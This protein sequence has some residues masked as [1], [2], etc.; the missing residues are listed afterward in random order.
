MNTKRLLIFII[1]T[2]LIALIVMVSILN[3]FFKKDLLLSKPFASNISF[4]QPVDD[5]TLY[6]FSGSSFVSYDLETRKSSALTPQYEL[7]NIVK[8]IKW[9]K[10]GA[11]LHAVGYSPNDMLYTVLVQKQLSPNSDY[12]WLFDFTS[13]TFSLV[14]D[15]ATQAQVR[16]A[17]WQTD[18][19]F[20]YTEK[21]AADNLSVIKNEAGNA[22]KIAELSSTDTLE[23]AT[24]NTLLY[25][26]SNNEDLNRMD[27]QSKQVTPISGKVQTVLAVG[28]DTS[29][30][31]L[32]Q[33]A[34]TTNSDLPRGAL[35]L[36]TA[37]ANKVET[38]KPDFSGSAVWRLDQDLWL[39]V[40]YTSNN[41]VQVIANPK[42]QV[43]SFNLQDQ[44]EEASRYYLRAAGITKNN[45]VLVDATN[46]LLYASDTA[47]NDILAPANTEQLKSGVS[48]PAFSITYDPAAKHFAV[49][50]Y[51]A[52]YNTTKQ[53]VL[54]YLGKYGY[55]PNQIPLHWYADGVATDFD[56]PASAAPIEAPTTT[57][58]TPS[59]GGD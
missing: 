45:Y 42:Q 48:E 38:L 13:D 28:T 31:F 16:N 27:I 8:E 44:R 49:Y 24:G 41:Q 46:D 11:L 10:N 56:L 2:A 4:S 33:S 21:Q 54:D 55:D 7:P 34:T 32:T 29:C 15:P 40:G 14:G 39:A 53:S 43:T 18:D 30:L 50:I 47:I 23:A 35:Q 9:S 5:K 58:T 1:P 3:F 17:V 25:L 51:K 22:S 26:S 57:I 20:V 37:K 6:Y 36:F 59:H 52:P 12:W 19:T